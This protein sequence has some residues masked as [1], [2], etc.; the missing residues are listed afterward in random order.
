MN[1]NAASPD[2]LELPELPPVDGPFVEVAPGTW[3]RAA[4]VVAVEAY[5]D[6]DWRELRDAGHRLHRW[7]H[8]ARVIVAGGSDD[9]AWWRSP[10]SPGQ[11]REALRLAAHSEDLRLLE[12]VARLAALAR[13]RADDGR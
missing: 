8:A 10:Y 11:L 12:A 4:A 1:P 13:R 5:A 7:E 2:P 3:M 6:H 9:P